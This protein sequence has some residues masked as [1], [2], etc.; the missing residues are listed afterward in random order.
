MM[1]LF[2]VLS[3]ILLTN[4][5]AGFDLD[6]GINME[7]LGDAMKEIQSVMNMFGGAD[8]T[9]GKKCAPGKLSV[10]YINIKRVKTPSLVM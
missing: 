2:S 4:L 1:N 8:G 7:E 9:C 5:A 10:C 6:L 3:A